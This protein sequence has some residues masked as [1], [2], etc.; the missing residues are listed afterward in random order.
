MISI[1][2]ALRANFQGA[3]PPGY[4]PTGGSPAPLHSSLFIL[5]FSLGSPCGRS[6]VRRR[7][8]LTKAGTCSFCPVCALG[9]SPVSAGGGKGGV[10]ARGAAAEREAGGT[11]L[12]H[13]RRTATSRPASERADG[14]AGASQVCTKLLPC[15]PHST[16][17]SC[18]ST[19]PSWSA[20]KPLLLLH[21]GA[22]LFFL[23]RR[24]GGGRISDKKASLCLANKRKTKN[25]K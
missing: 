17:S 3:E 1:Q 19:G 16:G 13:Q 7:R 5:R 10:R 20:P 23:Q 24:R 11:S 8:V 4:P 14:G 15:S 18:R 25:K 12:H 9:T 2:F 21:P 6:P 22:L